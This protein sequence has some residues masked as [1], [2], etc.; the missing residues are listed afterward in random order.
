MQQGEEV[1]QEKKQKKETKKKK[2]EESVRE[3][4]TD[5]IETSPQALENIENQSPQWVIFRFSKDLDPWVNL[6]KG[7][8]R[9]EE[10]AQLNVPKAAPRSL[11]IR[12]EKATEQQAGGAQRYSGAC[13]YWLPLRPGNKSFLIPGDLVSSCVR[14]GTILPGRGEVGDKG[15]DGFVRVEVQEIEKGCSVPLGYWPLNPLSSWWSAEELSKLKLRRRQSKNGKHRYLEGRSSQLQNMIIRGTR[16]LHGSNNGHEIVYLGAMVSST[17]RLLLFPVELYELSHEVV[18]KETAVVDEYESIHNKK[19]AETDEEED[20]RTYAEKAKDLVNAFSVAKKKRARMAYAQNQLLDSGESR[21]QDREAWEKLLAQHKK[22]VEKEQKESEHKESFKDIQF[23][24]LK[25]VLPIFNLEANLPQDIYREGV[26]S[27]IPGSV[28]VILPL[29][30]RFQELIEAGDSTANTEQDE[31]VEKCAASKTVEMLVRIYIKAKQKAERKEEKKKRKA[32]EAGLTPEEELEKVLGP[33][34]ESRKVDFKKPQEFAKQL[35]LLRG[36]IRVHT[37]IKPQQWAE[38]FARKQVEACI[39]GRKYDRKPVDGEVIAKSTGEGE[40]AGEE[41]TAE[42]A[43]ECPEDFP[44]QWLLART[45]VDLFFAKSGGAFQLHKQKVLAHI[46]SFASTLSPSFPE[47]DFTCL[48]ADLRIT[49]KDLR[50]MLKVMGFHPVSGPGAH[51]LKMELKAPLK[52][53]LDD[54]PNLNAYKRK[55]KG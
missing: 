3:E 19:D 44:K 31:L 29:T 13:A 16:V 25:E 26:R 55:K 18:K 46:C 23:R 40:V 2:E 52:L 54:E 35:A 45:W 4:L 22:S 32:K 47:F 39:T 41:K 14:L 42:K 1:Q 5:V 33:E 37:N 43:C 10:P 15:G 24:Q 38:N 8:V 30:D 7:R 27:I 49:A 53:P 36:L 50:D 9:L 21:S 17:R 6:H 51:I 28:R 48:A 34:G 11:G 12:V 20:L